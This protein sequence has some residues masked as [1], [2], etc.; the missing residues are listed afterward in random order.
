MGSCLGQRWRGTKHP[1]VD[2][3]VALEL[4][5]DSRDAAAGR[6]L[7]FGGVVEIEQRTRQVMID[8]QDQPGI[9][10]GKVHQ[11]PKALEEVAPVNHC[12]S[13]SCCR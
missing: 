6:Q 2:S 9:N 11:P 5:A 8:G 7:D 1:G 13:T 3:V 12:H 4:L 10:R